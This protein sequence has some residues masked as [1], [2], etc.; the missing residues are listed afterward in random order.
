MDLLYTVLGLA[1]LLLAL[2]FIDNKILTNIKIEE[3]LK[4]NNIAV[5]IFNREHLWV[6]TGRLPASDYRSPAWLRTSQFLPVRD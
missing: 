1:I 6:H 3:R 4:N 5:A 2:R